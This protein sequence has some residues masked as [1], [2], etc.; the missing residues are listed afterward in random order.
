VDTA[1]GGGWKFVR[2]Q[3][4][5]WPGQGNLIETTF[6]QQ[7]VSAMKR[8]DANYADWQ[9]PLT[10]RAVSPAMERNPAQRDPAPDLG[11]G[12]DTEMRHTTSCATR[13]HTDASR[14]SDAS[15]PS[16]M[17]RRTT[18][19]G[20]DIADR[21]HVAYGV[22]HCL[23]RCWPCPERYSLWACLALVVVGVFGLFEA[24]RG[25]CVARACGI[26]TRF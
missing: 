4:Q 24:A 22:W 16:K 19:R 1:V 26:K 21:T 3:F 12:E 25:W 11:W 18:G 15:L 13:P 8:F 6:R 5:I 17:K 2:V 14:I 10:Y 7:M 9:V 20:N 23:H